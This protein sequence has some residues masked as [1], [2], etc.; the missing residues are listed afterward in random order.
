MKIP[1]SLFLSNFI[2]LGNTA[3]FC[4][5]TFAKEVS[6][7]TE[8]YFLKCIEILPRGCRTLRHQGTTWQEVCR[9]L[10]KGT[11]FRALDLVK[12][13]LNHGEPQAALKL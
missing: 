6:V 1:D 13:Q 4:C 8:F 3:L 2:T 11:L 7:C 10:R 12:E 9:G 5:E